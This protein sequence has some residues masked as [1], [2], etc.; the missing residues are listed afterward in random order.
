MFSFEGSV[1]ILMILEKQIKGIRDSI[2]LMLTEVSQDSDGTVT[3]TRRDGTV[4][5]FTTG[6]GEQGAK[7]PKGEQGDK[8]ED[9]IGPYEMAVSLGY[10][11]TLSGIT[12]LRE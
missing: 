7:G 4:F 3:L 1:I 5:S 6:K 9:G 10:S 2:Q 8:G 11:G 12:V